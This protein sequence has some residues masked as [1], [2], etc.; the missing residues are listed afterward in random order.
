MN[1][2]SSSDVA[3]MADGALSVATSSYQY[4]CAQN[5]YEE[6]D[7]VKVA[8]LPVTDAATA[9]WYAGKADWD[10]AEGKA[11]QKD[12]I[13]KTKSSLT[14]AEVDAENV[15]IDEENTKARARAAQFTLMSW[16]PTTKVGFGVRG[17]FVAAWYC[18]VAGNPTSA[19]TEDYKENVKKDCLVD[20]VDK[21]YL[22]LAL[23]AHNAYRA[24]H[25]GGK[26]LET[27]LEAS[28]RIQAVLDA[29]GDDF[30]GSVRN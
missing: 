22:E 27:Y 30:D 20:G 13:D 4:A 9:G 29:A 2:V 3:N 1:A 12:R 24:Q 26:A 23:A 8:E 6:T 7:P 11:K 28:Q 21:C 14:D 10:F 16:R 17:K 19:T 18:E 5:V 15:K 25:K